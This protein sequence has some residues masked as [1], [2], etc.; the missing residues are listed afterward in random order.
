MAQ[1]KKGE[2]LPYRDDAV[3]GNELNRIVFEKYNKF[4]SSL[5]WYIITQSSERPRTNYDLGITT[6]SFSDIK[7]NLHIGSRSDKQLGQA[8]DKANTHLLKA[9]IVNKYEDSTDIYSERTAIFS[10]FK[11]NS[12]SKTLTVKLNDVAIPYLTNIT[13]NFTKYSLQQLVTLDSKYSQ[14]LFRLLSQFSSKGFFTVKRE[15]LIALLGAPKSYRNSNFARFKE[16]ILSP[17]V[18]EVSK[19]F[20]NLTY[21][22]AKSTSSSSTGRP[23]YDRV[24]FYFTPIPN[25]RKSINDNATV[26]DSPEPKNKRRSNKKPQQPKKEKSNSISSDDER[27]DEYQDDIKDIFG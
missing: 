14:S 7:Q 26:N 5:L 22:V 12:K 19:Y 13:K 27:A 24:D 21:E 8:L 2:L 1:D 6:Y 25:K 10:Q 18:E 4:D 16:K 11:V 20:N 17:A 3:Y 23:K 15:D 9:T